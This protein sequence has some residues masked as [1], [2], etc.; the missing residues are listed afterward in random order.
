MTKPIEN[1]SEPQ[2]VSP[3]YAGFQCAVS[4]AELKHRKVAPFRNIPL[5]SALFRTI[6]APYIIFRPGPFGFPLWARGLYPLNSR[7]LTFF[8]TIRTIPNMK[9]F[10][11]CSPSFA[12]AVSLLPISS[13]HRPSRQLQRSE[14]MPC[15]PDGAQAGDPQ[16]SSSKYYWELRRL[17]GLWEGLAHTKSGSKLTALQT[18]RDLSACASL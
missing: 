4:C 12:S 3:N 1:G 17:S 18:L 9:I 14:R 8:P 16:K 10:S 7:T 5:Q 2:P 6:S 15:T 11:P 13:A